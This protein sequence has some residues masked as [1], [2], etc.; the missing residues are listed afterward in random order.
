MTL[1]RPLEEYSVRHQINRPAQRQGSDLL[2]RIPN[3]YLET[4]LGQCV[5]MLYAKT[6]QKNNYN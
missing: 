5:F 1:E 4:G 2:Y 3:Q 6:K